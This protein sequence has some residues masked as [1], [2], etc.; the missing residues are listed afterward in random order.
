MA[1]N[2][3]NQEVVKAQNLPKRT[4]I[5]VFGILSVSFLCTFW[6]SFLGIIFGFIARGKSNVYVDAGVPVTGK[7]RVGRVLGTVGGI[8][9]IVATVLVPVVIALIVYAISQTPDIAAEIEEAI[10]TAVVA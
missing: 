9:S 3:T 1:N 2:E 7:V 8:I 4:P 6:L 5:L 10:R